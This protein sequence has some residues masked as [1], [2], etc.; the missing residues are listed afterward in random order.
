MNVR[1]KSDFE[2]K[3]L[4][5][6]KIL[7]CRSI[8]SNYSKLGMELHFLY[9]FV[10]TNILFDS[11]VLHTRITLCQSIKLTKGI[12]TWIIYMAQINLLAR[13]LNS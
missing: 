5:S 1:Q 8:F 7:M 9:I 6:D 13:F 4:I 3:S 10:S 11:S 2:F 12:L